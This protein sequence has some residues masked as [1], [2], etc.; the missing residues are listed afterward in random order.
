MYIYIFFFMHHLLCFECF[1]SD[2][3]EDSE[4]QESE[5][6]LPDDGPGWGGSSDE[7]TISA[8]TI[9]TEPPDYVE[10]DKEPGSHLVSVKLESELLGVDWKPHSL[11][12]SPRTR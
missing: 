1:V 7:S 2:A 11:V 5:S 8:N 3:Q 10:E 9:K 4:V 12:P 6:I